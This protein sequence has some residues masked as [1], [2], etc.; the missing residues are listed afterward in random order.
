MNNYLF[1]GKKSDSTNDAENNSVYQHYNSSTMRDRFSTIN[2]NNNLDEWKNF[3]GLADYLNKPAINFFSIDNWDKDIAIENANLIAQTS[4]LDGII[5][6]DTI[7]N[8]L[9]TLSTNI[10]NIN[11][12]TLIG[13]PDACLKNKDTDI[14]RFI[15]KIGFSDKD[16]T[17][18]KINIDDT[19][20][21]LTPNLIASIYIE[22]I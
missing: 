4:I 14:D 8:N 7:I 15:N 1:S 13:Q 19:L 22:A 18:D 5:S 17:Y 9:I 16:K 12:N 11:Y 21:L 20:S 2:Y 6:S 10:K 3:Q